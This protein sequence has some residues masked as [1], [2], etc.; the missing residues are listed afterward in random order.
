MLDRVFS[1]CPGIGPRTEARLA[2]MGVC[3]WD[4]FISSGKL[5]LGREKRD[6]AEDIISRSIEARRKGDIGFF[7]KHFPGRE[8][9]RVL[10][11]Y[12][13]RATFFDIETTGLSW[14]ESHATVITAYHRGDVRAFI[15]GRD[16]DSFLDLAS[17]AELLV[18]FNGSCFDLPF[19]ER[20]FSIPSL[21][22]PHIDLRWVAYHAGYRGGLKAIEAELGVRRPPEIEGIDGFEAV[23]LYY[24]WQAGDD[25]ALRM[26]VRYCSADAVSLYIVAHAL[27]GLERKPSLR[28]QA[29]LFEK[30]MISV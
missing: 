15:H 4:D 13:P 21:G 3:T 1:H 28:D 14:Y 17:E 24:R 11:E 8:H 22:R 6:R 10:R 12:L 27:A 5:P 20:T 29:A 9:W 19:I 30:A 2:E 7:V 26:L 23:N 25:G 18:S 16:L